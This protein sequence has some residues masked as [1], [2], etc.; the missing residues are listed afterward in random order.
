M[1]L[2]VSVVVTVFAGLRISG[3]AVC[4]V[5]TNEGSDSTELAEVQAVYCLGWLK[6]SAPSRRDGM[7]ESV[8][9]A[10]SSK[11]QPGMKITASPQD[12]T[13]SF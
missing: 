12:G 3:E 1:I 7:I 9:G 5:G 13:P 2:P 10:L 4:P 8:N 11:A 6:K